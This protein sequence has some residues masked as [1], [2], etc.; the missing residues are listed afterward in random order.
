VFK[1]RVWDWVNF[2]DQDWN[3]D[4]VFATKAVEKFNIIGIDDL[5][6]DCLHIL[7]RANT[8]VCLPQYLLPRFLLDK[9]FPSLDAGVRKPPR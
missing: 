4:A 1:K 3:E 6:C 5:N 9:L 8:S 7:H 2:A